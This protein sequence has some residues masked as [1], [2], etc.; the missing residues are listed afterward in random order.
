MHT[1]TSQD[2]ECAMAWWGVAYASGVNYNKVREISR[3][4]NKNTLRI[5]CGRLQF[6][7]TAFPVFLFTTLH[8]PF[9]QSC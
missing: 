7:L 8:F 1:L 2:P 5:G 9:S 6:T 4:T 3:E